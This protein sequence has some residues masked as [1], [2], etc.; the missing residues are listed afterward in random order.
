MRASDKE[1]A[2]RKV[3]A[4]RGHTQEEVLLSER[5][6]S[7]SGD[8]HKDHE[9][10]RPHACLSGWIFVGYLVEDE[11]GDEVEVFE[12]V[13]CKRCEEGQES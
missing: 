6:L 7:P 3:E 10:Q 2:S 5:G 4:P 9:E 1:V 8:P 13:P 12:P 11:N